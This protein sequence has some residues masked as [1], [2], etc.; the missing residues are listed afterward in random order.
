MDE[1]TMGAAKTSSKFRIT[2]GNLVI[3]DPR[4]PNFGQLPAKNGD[5]EADN[6]LLYNDTGKVCAESMTA[7]YM[8]PKRGVSKTCKI[9]SAWENLQIE[10]L[11]AKSGVIGIFDST[12]CTENDGPDRDNFISA[13]WTSVRGNNRGSS[14]RDAGFVS[15]VWDGAINRP[16]FCIG[17]YNT[18]GELIGIHIQFSPP[19]D[20]TA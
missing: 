6:H 1:T 4:W 18:G 8:D 15:L 19:A 13:C 11:E 20:A 16:Y 9:K 5:W 14:I 17:L 2:S 10:V 7:Y 12:C 3:A